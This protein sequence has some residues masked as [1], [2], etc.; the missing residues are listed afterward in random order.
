ME[1]LAMI[2]G[3]LFLGSS[4][5]DDFDLP[6]PYGLADYFAIHTDSKGNKRWTKNYGGSEAD[7]GRYI[8]AGANNT[9]YLVG[10]GQSN[11][12]DFPKRYGDFD[13][14]I[15][16]IKNDFVSASAVNWDF[17]LSAYPNPLKTN[18]LLNV[19]FHSESALPIQVSIFN[20][21]G[22]KCF[23]QKIQANEGKNNIEIPFQLPAGMYSLQLQSIDNQS[24]RLI[25]VE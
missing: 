3:L 4:D 21:M 17:E 6:K 1:V 15:I 13:I 24:S 8:V 23:M 18:D 2:C 16:K 10:Y 22:Q 11:T 12:N 14:Q 19:S 9:F 7:Y 20:L 25:L 5:S